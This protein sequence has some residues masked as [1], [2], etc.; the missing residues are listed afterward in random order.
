MMSDRGLYYFLSALLSRCDTIFD[1]TCAADRCAGVS[2][3]YKPS[4]LDVAAAATPPYANKPRGAQLENDKEATSKSSN[5]EPQQSHRGCF[6]TIDL[7]LTRRP[8][9]WAR[10][11]LASSRQGANEALLV[12]LQ[13]ADAGRDH[14][15][16]VYRSRAGGVMD[17]GGKTVEVVR[18]HNRALRTEAAG[19]RCNRRPPR[20]A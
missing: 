20:S 3:P 9:H 4:N 15:H 13:S 6:N 7:E 5:R 18:L 19:R 8:D 12:L 10:R 14:P 1:K 16:R 2:P 11:L 17:D